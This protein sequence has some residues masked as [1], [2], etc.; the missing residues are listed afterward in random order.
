MP[1]AM[2]HPPYDPVRDFAPVGMIT[3]L[4][5]VLV[6]ST[7]V[8]ARTM[9]EMLALLR[10]HP[11][12][13]TYA[14]KGIASGERLTGELFKAAVGAEIGYVDYK[15]VGPAIR[16]LRD[17]NIGMMFLPASMVVPARRH[18]RFNFLAVTSRQ[19]LPGL[20]EVPTMAEAGLPD[21]EALSWYGLFAPAGTP[22]AVIERL[23]T[24]LN[25]AVVLPQV[26][27]ELAKRGFMQTP[28]SPQD[29]AAVLA[30]DQVKWGGVIKP[31][32][33]KW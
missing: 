32:G 22:P 14:S 30:A 10:G 24:E 3:S 4:P 13:Y 18:D 31:L 6:A 1:N 9:P 33:L 16:D 12:G 7:M 15:A 27:G 26:G 5:Y 29:M 23:N 8:P 25:R 20:P 11:G 2:V 19:R 17:G 21:F 28:G